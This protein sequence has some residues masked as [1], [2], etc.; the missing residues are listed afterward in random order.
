MGEA[1]VLAHVVDAVQIVSGLARE[2]IDPDARIMEDLGIYGEDAYELLCAL[3]D[4]FEMASGNFH[5][6]IHFG[7]EGSV[8][9]PWRIKNSSGYFAPQPMSVREVACAVRNGRWPDTPR[10]PRARR[11]RVSL[12]VASSTLVAIFALPVIGLI[13]LL[14][15]SSLQALIESL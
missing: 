6:G 9:L 4:S 8:V 7:D 12:Y 15:A 11:H 1:E 5:L 14:I 2:R 13:V 10:I 3:D